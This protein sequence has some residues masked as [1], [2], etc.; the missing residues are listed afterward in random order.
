MDVSADAVLHKH[1]IKADE[2]RAR[3]REAFAAA[4]AATLDRVREQR[5]AAAAS[6]AELADAEDARL[7]TRR[8]RL[9]EGAK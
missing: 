2:Y 7:V 4:E 9:A 5:Q 3:A 1:Q 8:A 6:W